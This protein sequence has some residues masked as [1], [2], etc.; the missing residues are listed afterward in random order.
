MNMDDIGKRINDISALFTKNAGAVFLPHDLLQTIELLNKPPIMGQLIT[1]L[2]IADCGFCIVLGEVGIFLCSLYLP[3]PTGQ[4][5]MTQFGM[6]IPTILSP[7]VM[8]SVCSMD[9]RTPS[10]WRT[11]NEPG[12]EEII[13]KPL[14]GYLAIP[15]RPAPI[16][17]LPIAIFEISIDWYL[18]VSMEQVLLAR[19]ESLTKPS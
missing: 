12:T 19:R 4:P 9:L 16:E 11:F 3:R 7:T 15:F 18:S 1:G 10:L 17:V 5:V 8:V 14:T 2:Q 6:Q 13:N